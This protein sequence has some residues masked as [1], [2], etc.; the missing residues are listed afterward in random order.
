VTDPAT[1]YS[2]SDQWDIAQDPGTGRPSE[3]GLTTATTNAQG[4]VIATREARMDPYYLLMRLPNEQSDSFLILQ[5]F[6]PFSKD[7][8]RKELT[9]FMVAKSDPADYGKLKAFVMPRNGQVDG[10]SLINAKIQQNPDVSKQIS[11]LDQKG[12]EV[13]LGSLLLIPIKQS[14]LYIRPLY[15]QSAGTPLPQFKEAIV[16]YGDQVV[17]RETL[18]DALDQ[19]F[20]SS[21]AT[22][23]QK[24]TGGAPTA[25]TTPS[26]P[27][28]PGVSPTVKAL[29]DQAVAKF[30]AAQADLKNG[31]LAAYQTDHAAGEQLVQQADAALSGQSSTTTTTT[32]P[33]SSA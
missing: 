7:D 19:I 17:M 10:P 18:K 2:G 14:I 25:P 20:G 28:G 8:S 24:P 26:G 31:D 9:A 16:V 4:I 30:A 15:V 11:L 12:S 27:S 5:P 21:P 6:V 33:T 29:L 3:L 13:Q 22:L 23:E 32:T 1:F